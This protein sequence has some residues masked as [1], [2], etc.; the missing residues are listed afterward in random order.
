M[1]AQSPNRFALGEMFCTRSEMGFRACIVTNLLDEDGHY[2]DLVEVPSGERF[3]VSRA[4]L[5]N[6]WQPMVCDGPWHVEQCSARGNRA[7]WEADVPT[8]DFVIALAKCA[9][10]R[11]LGEII[12]YRT[13]EQVSPQDLGRLRFLNVTR[14]P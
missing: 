10:H 9:R 1:I 12:R 4:A 5:G 14:L 6:D 2:G 7:D 11:G 3:A 8:L 13:A